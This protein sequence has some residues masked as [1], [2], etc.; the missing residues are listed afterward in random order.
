[1]TGPVTTSFAYQGQHHSDAPDGD[2]S[3][4][5]VQAQVAAF[6]ELLHVAALTA[7]THTRAE[8]RAAASA[9][10][11]ANRSRIRAEHPRRHDRVVH[12]SG[13]VPHQQSAI[14]LCHAEAGELDRAST[15][16]LRRLK[17]SP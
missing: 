12:L 5:V 14:G 2:E 3:D 11:R 10:N 4:A 7:P 13:R 17:G 15:A 8:L 1:M 9:F 6:G 16:S